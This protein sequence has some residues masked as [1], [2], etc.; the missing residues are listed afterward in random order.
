MFKVVI[1]KWMREEKQKIGTINSVNIELL[2]IGQFKKK[3]SSYE[4]EVREIGM[5]N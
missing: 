1:S 2:I 5:K 3:G 4:T